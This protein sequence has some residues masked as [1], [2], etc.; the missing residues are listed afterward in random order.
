[1][2]TP[3]PTFPVELWLMII[4]HLRDEESPQHM[5]RLAQTSKWFHEVVNDALYPIMRLQSNLNAE[6]F[7]FSMI[8]L[9]EPKF[10]ARPE[11]KSLVREVR[12]H[13]DMGFQNFTYSCS[14]FYEELATFHNLETLIMRPR[15]SATNP[16]L[17]STLWANL[18]YDT[19]MDPNGKNWKRKMRS[20]FKQM[21][22]Q[23]GPAAL[24]NPFGTHWSPTNSSFPDEEHVR[25]DMTRF[26]DGYLESCKPSSLTSCKFIILLY[27]CTRGSSN[28]RQVTSEPTPSR[29]PTMPSALSSTGRS[30]SC[31][32]SKNSALL[33]RTSTCLTT[34]SCQMQA[35]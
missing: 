17:W 27:R 31:P 29:S 26:C 22:K 20:F 7:A 10:V 25:A 6:K 32:S 11:V 8:N 4:E 21:E 28:I 3:P 1:M 16:S 14:L 13:G 24:D 34:T 23:D 35:I 2:S 18:V 9:E 30:V 12:H 5:S 19:C 15:W 33:A